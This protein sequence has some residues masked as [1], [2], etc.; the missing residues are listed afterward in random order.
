MATAIEQV[1]DDTG[2]ADGLPR[3][4]T[5]RSRQATDRLIIVGGGMAAL[6]L[7]KSL[8]ESGGITDFQTTIFGEEPQHA[9]DRVN[10]SKIFDGRSS[11]DLLLA[12]PQ[13]YQQHGIQFRV[14]SR[15]TGIDRSAKQVIDSHGTRH[16]YDQLVLAT[17]SHAWMPPIPGHDSPGVF[18]YRTLE[19]L[20]KIQQHVSNGG[21]RS[22][23]VIGGGLLGLEAAKVLFDLGLKTS[24]IEMAPG[25]M[26]RQLDSKAAA[27]LKRKVESIGVDVHLVRRTKS[28]H[29]EGDGRIRIAFENA[30]DA[31]ADILIVAA[32]VR[33]NDQLAT[34][35]GLDLGPRGGI[36]VDSGLRTSDPSIYAIGECACFRD[37]VYGLVAPCYRM[38]DVLAQRLSGHDVVFR[39]ADESAELKLMG[40]Q[41]AAL[42]QGIGQ[43]SG[44]VLA[45]QDE[46]G[47][48]K[49]ILQ[50]GRVIGAACVG[51][52]DELPQI[53]QAIHQQQRLWP[54]QRSRFRRTGSP[55]S[56]GGSLPITHWPG[57]SI[58]CSCLGVTK[59]RLC[60]EIDRGF[61]ST[62]S[63]SQKTGAATACGNCRALLCELA[64][65]VAESAPTTES[66]VM[67]AA[68]V[69]SA[70]FVAM[71]VVMPPVEF[72][73]SVQDA[74]RNVDVLW[75][76][77]L[78]RQITGYTSLSMV[79]LGLLFSLRKRMNWFHF[80]SYAFW[81][82][83][84]GVLGAA[85]LV[86]VAVHTGFRL[87]DNLN[88]VLA[89]V[90]LATAAIG[91]M[92]GIASGMENRVTGSAAM[93][94]R[95]WRPRLT[96]VHTW[97]FWPLPALI[98]VHIVS[99]YWF[100]E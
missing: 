7:C 44:V 47:Y 1:V 50:Q 31:L 24:V 49:I 38:A 42:G 45:Q 58:V 51:D 5:D 78:A 19:D 72:A 3:R 59:D 17:G 6:G 14:G 16:D 69:L 15:V 56:P 30:G 86:S 25:L 9:Y 18:V 35:C 63:L 28:I 37:H 91:S 82:S 74:W 4:A 68:S 61:D 79:M 22:G 99:F 64:G 12:P 57:D 52:W 41:V 40:V 95:R 70:I 65:T 83:V 73:S 67:L 21:A 10:L 89:T 87:G 84:H 76:S 27:I 34:D 11:D 53:R 48:R 77:D 90:F 39:G 81:R 29:P 46:T 85:V 8:V 36:I 13:W 32:G 23:A 88:F 100:S 66:R 97:L 93:F 96:Q 80:G 92:A 33:P 20:R 94:I 98:A 75:R 62:E 26:P 54:H 2:Q 71:V 55:W 60:S 43:T